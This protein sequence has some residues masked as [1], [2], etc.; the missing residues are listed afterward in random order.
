MTDRVD[1]L[2]MK[3]SRRDEFTKQWSLITTSSASSEPVCNDPPA[4]AQPSIAQA[5]AAQAAEGKTRAKKGEAAALETPAVPAG[6]KR[7]ST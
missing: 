4:A 6:T 2:Y 5:T 1:I 3:K 7:S